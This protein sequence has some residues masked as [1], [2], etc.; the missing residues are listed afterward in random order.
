VAIGNL[1]V[2]TYRLAVQ[3]TYTLNTLSE[4]SVDYYGHDLNTRL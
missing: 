4:L 2:I 1:R 3:T